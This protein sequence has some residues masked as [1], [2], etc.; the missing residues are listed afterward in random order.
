MT[1]RH[2]VMRIGT[3]TVTVTMLPADPHRMMIWFH[4]SDEA[5]QFRWI[6]NR[7]VA[8]SVH[9]F[10]G[11]YRIH[12]LNPHHE[13]QQQQQQQSEINYF[14]Y[15]LSILIDRERKEAMIIL[16]SLMESV[17]IRKASQRLRDGLI[18]LIHLI[19]Y[20]LLILLNTFNELLENH[21]FS[22]IIYIFNNW[23]IFGL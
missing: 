9:P 17:S 2:V 15:P 12:L 16:R 8:A 18:W 7:D 4:P 19:K 1:T 3:T 10:N 5:I 21:K 22:I 14:S 11:Y 6:D 13:Q 23:S 20:F